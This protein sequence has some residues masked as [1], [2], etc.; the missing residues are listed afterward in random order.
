MNKYTL[1]QTVF[2]AN[3]GQELVEGEVVHIFTHFNT[4]QYVI[5]YHNTIDYA[6]CVREWLTVADSR[7]SGLNIW[8]KLKEYCNENP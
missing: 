3:G 8:G 7:E 1:G 6:I 2:F 4:E 5:E